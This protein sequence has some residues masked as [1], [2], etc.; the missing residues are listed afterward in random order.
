ML[1][2]DLGAGQN[3]TPGFKGVDLWE[4]ADIVH[5]LTKFPYPFEDNSVSEIVCSHFVEH[6]TGE[7][8]IQFMNECYRILKP[9]NASLHQAATEGILKITSPYYT[10]IRCWQDPTHKIA[11]SESTFLYYNKKW[12]EDNKLTHHD[13]KKITC[14]F[15]YTYGYNVLHPWST[16]NQEALQFAIQHYHN[17]VSDITIMLTK[18]A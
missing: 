2:L 8:L 17:V 18:R 6:L 3:C 16:K 9:S 15:D 11:I 1:K 5:D 7:Q 12:R 14:D 4:G 10:S 13:Y